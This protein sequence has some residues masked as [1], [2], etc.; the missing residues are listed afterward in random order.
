VLK[1]FW[2]ACYPVTNTQFRAFIENGYRKPK[3]WTEAGREWRKRSASP[4]GGYAYDPVAGIAN[5]PVTGITWHEAVAFANWL[6]EKTHKRYRL[7]TEAEWE[8][9]A[10]GLEHR[11]YPFV[12][13]RASDDACNTRECG[14]GQS[15]AVGIFP[16]DRTPEG[17]YDMGGNVWE[18]CSTLFKEQ[19]YQ[20]D[21]G[22]EDLAVPGHRILRGGSYDSAHR[23][24]HCS[25]RLPADPLSR[26]RMIG[27]RL[28]RDDK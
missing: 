20:P 2:L 17:L 8:R 24:I 28:A 7:P 21:D 14:V 19:P 25:Q 18:W 6:S 9:A 15:T 11:K 26:I 10:A 13:S 27:F 22:R 3:Y 4:A 5:R 23:Q 1:P 12:G 16:E